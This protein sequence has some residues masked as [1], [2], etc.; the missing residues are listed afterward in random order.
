MK[1][2]VNNMINTLVKSNSVIVSYEMLSEEGK[3]LKK[4]QTLNVMSNEATDQDFFDVGS[5]VG[6]MLAYAVKEI[7]K[8]NVTLLLEE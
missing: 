5:A 2:R 3:L 6:N 8:S 7:F 1:D 4:R